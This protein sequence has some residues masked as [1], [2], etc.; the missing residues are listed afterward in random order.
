MRIYEK[1]RTSQERTSQR[2][3]RER[4]SPQRI[5]CEKS[6]SWAQNG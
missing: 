3:P 4:S 6:D 5:A 1:E 2:A